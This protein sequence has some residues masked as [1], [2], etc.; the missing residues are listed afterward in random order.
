VAASRGNE[1]PWDGRPQRAD[2]VCMAL[3][4]F[5]GAYALLLLPAVP[6]LV[7]THPVLLELFRGS[8]TSMV[9]MGAL[10]RVGQASLLVAILAAIPGSMMFDWLY[11]W[12]GKRWGRRALAMFVGQHPKAAR[13]M[14]WAERVSRRWGWLAVA[15]AYVMPIPSVLIYAAVGWTG[16]RLAVFLLWDLVGA[17]LWILLVVGLGYAIG[18]RAVDVAHA[19]SHYALALTL[20]LVVAIVVR[21]VWVARRRPAPEPEAEPET[22]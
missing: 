21:Q 6:S 22:P 19:V 14:A 7:G 9:T 12:A 15:L 20:L 18:Q 4:A 5:S 16:M 3:I 10:A 2:I 17:L 1:L 13:R 8:M 11:W